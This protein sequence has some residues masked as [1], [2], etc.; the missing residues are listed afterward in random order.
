MTPLTKRNARVDAL[1]V[2][3]AYPA[4]SPA[5]LI[6]SATLWVPPNVPPSVVI[7]PLR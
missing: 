7:A 5:L 6:A 1:P 2:V 4:T 3:D